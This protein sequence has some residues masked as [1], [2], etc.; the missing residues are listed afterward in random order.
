MGAKVT[1]A[2]LVLVISIAIASVIAHAQEV[3]ALPAFFYGKAIVNGKSVPLNSTVIA[4]I[5]NEKRG[6]IKVTVAG[7]YGSKDSSEKLLVT[8]SR[9]TSGNEIQ[10]FVKIPKLQEIKATQTANWESGLSQELNL[11]FIGPEIVD[12]STNETSIEEF[13]TKEIYFYNALI[14][15]KQLMI[16]I[17]NP[18]IP[19][20]RL[21]LIVNR[22]LTNV[23]FE[24]EVIDESRLPKS[25]PR[26]D[27]AYK[28]ISINAPKV[29][30]SFVQTAILKFKVANEWFDVNGH[31]PAK[32]KLSRYNKNKWND[33]VTYYE[34][35]DAEFNYYRA[36]TPGFSYFA[37][38]ASVPVVKAAELNA[39]A[40]QKT[41]SEVKQQESKEKEG[42]KQT[43]SKVEAQNPITGFVVEKVKAN[44]MIGVVLVLVGMLIGILATYFF[45]VKKK[46]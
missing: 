12:N 37:I 16:V 9:S 7:L 36:V 5:N 15:G 43:E 38:K 45:V 25:I 3:P 35:N 39:T 8:G 28:Y 42:P 21:Q 31:D 20:T 29:E 1:A 27:G 46:E 19:I 32:V 23:T 30:Q 18:N 40:T 22:N 10:F 2:L 44:P 24:F 11:T 13:P 41:E 6:Q 33:L 14:A 34:G 17:E 4:K 26:L